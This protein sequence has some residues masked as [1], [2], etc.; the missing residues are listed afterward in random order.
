MKH[1]L[2]LAHTSKNGLKVYF[3]NFDLKYPK[4]KTMKLREFFNLI[5]SSLTSKH[6]KYW[7][8]ENINYHNKR[9]DFKNHLKFFISKKHAERVLRKLEY[10]KKQKIK[11]GY[12]WE[13]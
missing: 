6:F 3:I 1:I 2:K 12:V 10:L 9:I 4:I 7:D 8:I 11:R 13:Q 5:N